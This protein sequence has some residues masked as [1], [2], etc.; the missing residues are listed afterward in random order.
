MKHLL[1]KQKTFFMKDETKSYEFRKK[2]L[3][4]LKIAI[5]AYEEELIKALYEDLHKSSIEA[6]TTEIG[7]V[8][9]SIKVASKKFKEMDEGRKG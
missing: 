8:Y 9:K 5:K 7:F 3:E 4:Q 6:Y 2:Q 1:D